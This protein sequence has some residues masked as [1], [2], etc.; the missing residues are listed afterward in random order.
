MPIC[1]RNKRSYCLKREGILPSTCVLRQGRVGR[2]KASLRLAIVEESCSIHF[3][4]DLVAP[5]GQVSQQSA[6]AGHLRAH[7]G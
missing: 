1:G 4:H 5:G 3:R 6:K 2:K 7:E